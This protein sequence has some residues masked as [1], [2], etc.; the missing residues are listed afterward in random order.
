MTSLSSRLPFRNIWTTL[1]TIPGCRV[2]TFAGGQFKIEAKQMRVL[3]WPSNLPRQCRSQ[4]RI[5]M[6]RPR[7]R[8]SNHGPSLSAQRTCVSSLASL[9]NIV[10]AATALL[11][12]GLPVGYAAKPKTKQRQQTLA[13]NVNSKSVSS[14]IIIR[15]IS[16]PVLVNADY[17]KPF[18]VHFIHSDGHPMA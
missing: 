2:R 13:M 10:V 15:L 16:P 18:T 14:T 7:Q 5:Q 1:L 9:V 8:Q 11:L 6:I 4:D 12:N 3:E 17:N